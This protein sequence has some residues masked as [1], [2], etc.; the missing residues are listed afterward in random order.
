MFIRS[1]AGPLHP[2]TEEPAVSPQSAHGRPRRPEPPGGTHSRSS[3]SEYGCR[4]PHCTIRPGGGAVGFAAKTP[5]Y[6]GSAPAAAV[7]YS[8]MRASNR[9]GSG[10]DF[11]CRATGSRS[12]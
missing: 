8:E 7:R 3:P 4:R 11:G 2:G 1:P 9:S 6:P 10:L 12:A 5:W